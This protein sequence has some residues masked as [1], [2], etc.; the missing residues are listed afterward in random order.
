MLILVAVAILTYSSLIY[1]AEREGAQVNNDDD[2]LDVVGDGQ[3]Y[4]DCDCLILLLLIKVM[5]MKTVQFV[6]TM[7]MIVDC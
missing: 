6:F 1:F 7:L 5:E 2:H 3:N 4:A